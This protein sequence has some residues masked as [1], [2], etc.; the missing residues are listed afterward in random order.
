MATNKSRTYHIYELIH[1]DTCEP[2]YV[3]VT[4]YLASR[5]QEHL[6]Y[7]NQGKLPIQRII[8]LLREEGKSPRFQIVQQ[9]RCPDRRVANCH[10]RMWINHYRSLGYCLYQK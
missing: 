7:R 9:V 10:E 6:H 1:P 4:E 3:G 2:M 8:N 5:Q